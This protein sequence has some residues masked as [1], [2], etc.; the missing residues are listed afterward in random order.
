MKQDIISR[1]TSTLQNLLNRPQ[2]TTQQTPNSN[3]T[4]TQKV[5]PTQQV[6]TFGYPVAG[7]KIT[8]AYGNKPSNPNIRYESGTNL[9]TDF[10]AAMGSA[11]SAPVGGTVVGINSGAGAWGN[12]VIIDAGDGRQLAFNHLSDFGDIK[13]GQAIKA[14]DILGKVGRTGQTT[15][16]HLDM[17]ATVNGTSVPL[18]TAFK[19]YQFDSAY[20]GMESG[21]KGAQGYNRSQNS[22]YDTND[23]SKSTGSVYRYGS[24]GTPSGS[25]SSSGSSGSSGVNDGPRRDTR[26]LSETMLSGLGSI[27]STS[28]SGITS[29]KRAGSLGFDING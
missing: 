25:S 11:I 13:K 19:G 1:A 2:A 22:F 28:A 24:G 23:L 5:T 21:V 7:A 8:Q 10:G 26:S 9:G 6:Q 15:G 17:E 16:P 18:S 14:G 3:K 20:G 4:S 12:Q 29:T 27:A